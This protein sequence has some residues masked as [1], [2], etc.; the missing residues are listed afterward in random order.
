MTEDKNVHDSADVL[1]TLTARSDDNIQVEPLQ[2]DTSRLF[3]Q[4]TKKPRQLL[5]WLAI[6]GIIGTTGGLAYSV[7]QRMQLLEQQ[8]IA[9]QDSFAKISGDAVEHI[10]SISGQLSTSQTSAQSEIEALR[11]TTAALQLQYSNIEPQLRKNTESLSSL[12]KQQQQLSQH[13]DQQANAVKEGLLAVDSAQQQLDSQVKLNLKQLTELQQEQSQ[14]LE[15]NLA[16]NQRLTAISAEFEAVTEHTQ[17]LEEQLKL[18]Q[19]NL[20]NTHQL[21]LGLSKVQTKQAELEQEFQAY[22]AQITR[23]IN[24]LNEARNP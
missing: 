15:L 13:L 21:Q 7:Q 10:Q 2:G 18:F 14:Q 3:N 1:P 16:Y 4:P 20:Q 11:K 9:T 17:Q 12:T 5:I 8:L 22:R 19:D 24:A 6:T 23:S